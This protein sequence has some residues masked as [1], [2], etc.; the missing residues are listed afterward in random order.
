LFVIQQ[1]IAEVIFIT[2]WAECQGSIKLTLGSR[3]LCFTLL[4]LLFDL[5]K[6]MISLQLEA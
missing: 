5:T 4:Q 3:K 1:G 6:L 2:E